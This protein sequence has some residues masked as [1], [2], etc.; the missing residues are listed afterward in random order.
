VPVAR[1]RVGELGAVDEVGAGGRGGR[2]QPERAVDMHPGAVLAAERDGRAQ[3]VTGAGVDVA[4]LQAQDRRPGRAC[5]ERSVQ[6]GEVDRAVRVGCDGLDRGLA[7]AEQARG[8]VDRGVPLGARDDPHPRRAGQS[9]AL[10]VPPCGPQHVVAGGGQPDGVG[11]LRAGREP[12]SGGG[13][14][15]QQREQPTARGAFGR[16]RRGGQRVVER[17]LVP[18]GGE[19][20]CRGGGGERAADDEAEVARARTAHQPA[21][22]RSD[23][24]V[25]DLLGRGAHAG[26]R[27]GERGQHRVRVGG[28]LDRPLGERGP[29]VRGD[30]RGALQE[31]C[32][33]VVHDHAS[34]ERH[35]GPIGLDAMHV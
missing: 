9:V 7:E 14:Q 22:G 20:V 8:P 4:G 24:L 11:P 32:E 1:P 34:Y 10:D 35:A 26:Q 25:N 12:D 28:R 33:L 5:G 27:P 13:R 16:R 29:V 30:G 17:A 23:E 21:L 18:P 31:P 15:A 6:V 2:P 19:H 3:V